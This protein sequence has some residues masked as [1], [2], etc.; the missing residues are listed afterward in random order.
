MPQLEPWSYP[1]QIF[2]LLV[3]FSVLFLIV[4]RIVTPGIGAIKA[5]RQQK[6]DADLDKAE[7]LKKKAESVKEGYEADLARAAQDARAIHQ[8][9]A[10][11]IARKA[12]KEHGELGAVLAEKAREA[13]ERIAAARDMAVGEMKSASVDV[14]QA[15]TEKL[16]GVSVDARAAQA[17]LDAVGKEAR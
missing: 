15:A 16:I 4:W 17:A 10:D 3:T 6:L 12:E 8:Q 13:N 9:A 5:N 14:V 1:S 2:W 7:S 11:E